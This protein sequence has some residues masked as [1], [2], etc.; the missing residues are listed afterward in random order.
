MKYNEI[1]QLLDKIATMPFSHV[2]IKDGEFKVVIDQE[3]L[4]EKPVSKIKVQ[5]DVNETIFVVKSPLVG[6]IHFDKMGEVGTQ[7][8][9]KEVIAQIE[10]MKLYNDIQSSVTGVILERLVDDGELVEFNQD[11]FKIRIDG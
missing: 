11:L 6:L 7:V 9:K 8:T 10:S 2:E 3:Q 5:T 1:S 4:A